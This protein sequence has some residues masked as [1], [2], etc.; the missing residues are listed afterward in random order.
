MATFGGMGPN[1]RT[2]DP[3][4]ERLT[5]ANM[6]LADLTGAIKDV[7]TAL[8]KLE[9]MPTSA[10]R[11]GAA[12]AIETLIEQCLML[13]ARALDRPYREVK[14]N[15]SAMRRGITSITKEV[16]AAEIRAQRKSERREINRAEWRAAQQAIR[17][18]RNASRPKQ[19]H[20]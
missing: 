3:S 4:R 17:N 7:N 11:M 10:N 16:E 9:D 6:V 20:G 1:L 5:P 2:A 13:R 12:M 18:A 19:P 8:S 14:I 15:G